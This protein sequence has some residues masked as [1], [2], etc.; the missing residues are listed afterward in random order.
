MAHVAVLAAVVFFNGM[1]STRLQGLR[2]SNH[3]ETLKNGETFYT[4]D[5]PGDKFFETVWPAEDFD[6]VFV[7]DRGRCSGKL[8]GEPERGNFLLAG[9]NINPL[10][11]IY[12]IVPHKWIFPCSE[13]QIAK[14]LK[15]VRDALKVHEKV[16]IYGAS[17]GASLAL[18][19]LSRLV[20]C[21]QAR[22]HAVIAEAPF[23]SAGNV[24]VD[25]YHLPW[26]VST[27]VD[28]VWPVSRPID[29]ELPEGVPI[30]IGSAQNDTV[31]PSAGQA[32]LKERNPHVELVVV[33]G[34]HHDNI[35]QDP[36]YRSRVKDFISYL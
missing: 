26:W 4:G 8:T 21:E 23:D 33:E 5:E 3:V 12:T 9:L 7:W 15:D 34:A 29:V 27:L 1:G 14:G 6:D 17:R 28:S 35:W 31:C 36:Y 20:P 24:M 25:R 32:R 11:F 10:S 13:T 30:L 16:I 22:I 18:L 19:V 2:Y